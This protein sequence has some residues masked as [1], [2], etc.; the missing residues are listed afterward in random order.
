MPGRRDPRPARPTR[1]CEANGCEDRQVL[2]ESG[3][4]LSKPACNVILRTLVGRS[5][6]NLLGFVEF[7]ELAQQKKASELSHTRRLLHIVRDDYNCK[8]FFE[9]EYQFFDLASRSE[10]RRVGKECRSR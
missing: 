8:L 10:E 4:A 2:A 5:S 7:D 1:P 6:K 3:C 9:L